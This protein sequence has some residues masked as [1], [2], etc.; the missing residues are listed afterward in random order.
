MKASLS[1][2]WHN[3]NWSFRSKLKIGHAKEWNDTFVLE[4]S[5]KD[6]SPL[7]I[8]ERLRNESMFVIT[9]E[10]FIQLS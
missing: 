6:F 5:R 7:Y 1:E 3:V 8:Q 2:A 9:P 4:D 10:F